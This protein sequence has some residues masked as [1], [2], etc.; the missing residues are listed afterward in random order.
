MAS[1]ALHWYRDT[2]KR[3]LCLPLFLCHDNNLAFSWP[4]SRSLLGM[5]ALCLPRVPPAL[6]TLEQR[7]PVQF[8]WGWWVRL[9]TVIFYL[10]NPTKVILATAFY[11]LHILLMEWKK[12]EE[13]G[14]AEDRDPGLSAHDISVYSAINSELI[15]NSAWNF[16]SRRTE[17][18][19]TAGLP[20]TPAIYP[21]QFSPHSGEHCCLPTHKVCLVFFK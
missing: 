9:S 3:N 15:L 1:I 17:C 18:W 20:V 19:G 11:R 14:K 4:F 7:L 13:E 12:T 8:V 2:R 16:M 21:S 6:G 5:C 10:L